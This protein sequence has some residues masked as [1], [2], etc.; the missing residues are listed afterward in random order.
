[1]KYTVLT[2]GDKALGLGDGFILAPTLIDLA[3]KYNVKHIGT[4]QSYNILKFIKV[5]DLEI[6]NMDT[7]G[8]FYNNDHIKT[9]N[10]TYWDYYNSLRNFGC[11][12]IN[13]TRKIAGLDLYDGILPDIPISEDIESA[14]IKLYKSLKRPIVISQILISYWNKMIEP[15]QYQDIINNLIDKNLT[16]IQIG[17]PGA[18]EPYIN[19]K[20]INLV[21][22]TS[23]EQSM[24][25]I[26][27]ADLFVGSDSFCQHCAAFM[28]T[29]SVVYWAGT[30]PESFGYNFFS[31]ITY[32]E[33]AT[34]QSK[35][36]RPQR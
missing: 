8:Y 11:H 7:Q 23:I 24:A 26:K 15:Y 29:P 13:A 18:V 19:S 28:R 33:I 21:G 36:A 17:G 25:M 9:Y 12:A 20:T 4:N 31:N 27:H 32:P 22:Q 35:C 2:S 16:V 34:C 30:S 6:F 3:K 10:L 14:V 5:P 1:M